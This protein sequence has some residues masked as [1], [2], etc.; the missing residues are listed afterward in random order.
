NDLGEIISRSIQKIGSIL[1]RLTFGFSPTPAIFSQFSE[2]TFDLAEDLMNCELWDPNVLAPP[3]HEDVPQP[4]RLPDNIPFGE[5][6]EADV[7]LPLDL[8]G[9]TEGYIDD[10]TS[11]VL[12]TLENKTMVK[13]ARLCS[14]SLFLTCRPLDLENE[15]IDRSPITSVRKL[16]AEGGLIEILIFLGWLINTRLFTIGLPTEKA[17]AWKKSIHDI[18]KKKLA[19]Y[20]SLKTI[21]GQ[22]EH[23]CF[24]I[25]PARHFMNR[26]RR[27]K[28]K[29]DK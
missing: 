8:K 7:K 16:L 10:G 25:P 21:E 18:I 29:A 5:A 17:T 14:M 6:L 27:L 24:V 11:I 9:G 3:L 12:G 28:D 15:P 13:R 4:V 19:T 23:T 26:L 1:T 20:D 22:L 2:C